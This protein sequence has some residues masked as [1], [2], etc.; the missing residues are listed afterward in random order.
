MNSKYAVYLMRSC[1]GHDLRVIGTGATDL[2][3]SGT[4]VNIFFL[5]NEIFSLNIYIFLL[6]LFLLNAFLFR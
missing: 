1:F 6:N 4:S 2:L 5:L 3:G